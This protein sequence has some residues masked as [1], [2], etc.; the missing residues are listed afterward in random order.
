MI[1]YPHIASRYC[2][3]NVFRKRRKCPN[4]GVYAKCKRFVFSVP[5]SLQRLGKP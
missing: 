2:V 1:P 3:Q 5:Y 4:L